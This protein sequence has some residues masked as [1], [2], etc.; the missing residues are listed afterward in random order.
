[1]A[2][3]GG[4]PVRTFIHAR[5]LTQYKSC[6]RGPTAHETSHHLFWECTYAQDLLKALSTELGIWIPTLCIT[7]D[8]VMYNL[9]PGTHALGDLQD[10]WR[11]LC[12][13]KDVLLFSKNRLIVGK[14]ETSTLGCRK[15]I[16]S[17]V[18]DYAE[19]DGSDDNSDIE[20]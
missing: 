11:L 10:C 16:R 4:L 12:C 13:F 18:C 14:K 20:T 9:F 15:M 19:L 2:I 3:Q 7:A 5:W 17:L 8:S 6:P 1:M